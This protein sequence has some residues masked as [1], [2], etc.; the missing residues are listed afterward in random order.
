[1][2][3]LI[4]R[5]PIAN[6][7]KYGGFGILFANPACGNRTGLKNHRDIARIPENNAPLTGQDLHGKPNQQ[8]LAITLVKKQTVR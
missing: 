6:G 5:L 8:L 2:E 1:M 7:W 4:G 3:A